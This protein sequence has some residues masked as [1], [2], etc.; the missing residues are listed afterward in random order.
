METVLILAYTAWAIYSG[1]KVL[2]GRSEWLDRRAPLNMVV[3]I[4]LSVV[5]GY[6]IAAFYL[7]YLILKFLGV[8]SRM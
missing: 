3:K 4:A 2:S 6:V 1:Y 5:V 8:M 7:I